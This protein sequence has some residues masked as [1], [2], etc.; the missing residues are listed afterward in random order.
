MENLTLEDVRNQAREKLKGICAVYPVCDGGPDR[1]CQREN[2]GKAIGLGGVGLGGSFRANIEALARVRL[3]T[4]V[5]GEAFV[6]DSAFE[7]FGLKLSMPILGASTSGMSAYNGAITEMDFCRATLAGCRQAG[8]LSFRGDTYFYDEKDH[9]ALTSVAEE[10]GRGVPI[11][12]PRDQK[13]LVDLV[14]R[15]VDLGVPAVGVDLDG[16]GSTN[17]ARAGKAVFRKSPAEIAE[18]VRVAGIP[19]L[20]KGIMHPDDAQACADAGVA[21]VVVSNHG[22]RVLDGTPGTATVLP[23]IARRVGHRVMVLADGGVR[24]G[25]DAL[26]MLGLGAKA[27]LVGRDLIRAGIGGGAEGVRLQMDRHL[28]VFRQAMVMTGCRTLAD[29]GP[30]ILAGETH[31]C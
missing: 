31:P 20:A 30:G 10:G 28:A 19:F 12:K 5:V 24:N 21:A 9:W 2:Y 8:T 1:I 17:F 11:F 22:G 23:E 29:I 25:A 27:V 18:L 16:H 13:V 7:F 15:A 14:R 26:K 6:P 4:R 3:H